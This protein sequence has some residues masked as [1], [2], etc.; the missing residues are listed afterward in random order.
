MRK[1]G[2]D[3][4]GFSFALLAGADNYMKWAREMC[5][6]LDS[7]GLWDYTLPDKE[8]PKPVTIILKDK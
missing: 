5:Y 4:P 7:A 3:E 8:N 6:S 1:S 2:N